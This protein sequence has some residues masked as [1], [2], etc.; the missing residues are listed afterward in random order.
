MKTDVWCLQWLLT[1]L[2]KVWKKK[3]WWWHHHHQSESKADKPQCFVIVDVWFQHEFTTEEVIC[4]SNLCS[5]ADHLATMVTYMGISTRV[6]SV[7]PINQK[8]KRS[9]TKG[10]LTLLSFSF[11]FY[12]SV[13]I[14]DIWGPVISWW[15]LCNSRKY[16]NT[17]SSKVLHDML[18]VTGIWFPHVGSCSADD[19]AGQHHQNCPMNE[20]AVSPY[21][22][23]VTS[24]GSFLIS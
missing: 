14:Y 8:V 18:S 5:C 7:S 1:V 11:C 22:F 10:A 15:T 24:L 13:I 2:S 4:L 9:W 20:S 3:A 19:D 21:N 6:Q 17:R 16:I 12:L 23:M